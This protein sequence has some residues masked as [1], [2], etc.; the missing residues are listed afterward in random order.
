M[1][2]ANLEPGL[3][4]LFRLFL[5]VQLL[6]IYGNVHVHGGRGYLGNDPWNPLIFSA[7]SILLLLAYLSIP[8][9][10]KLLGA[11]YLPLALILS[12]VISL[13]AQDLLLATRTLFESGSSEEIAWQL[14]LFLFIPLVLTAWQYNFRAVLIFCLFSAAFDYILV[15]LGNPDFE[16]VQMTYARL[17]LIRTFAFLFVGYTIAR[18]VQQMRQQSLAL[19]QAND[20]LAHYATTLEQLSVSRERNRLA[21]ELHDTLAHTLSGLAVQLEGIRSII[22]VNPEKSIAM[23]ER[24]IE[25]TRSGLTET[26]KSIQSLRATPVDDLGIDL[27]IQELGRSAA[28]RA[29]FV[30]NFEKSEADWELPEDM[31]Q[32]LYRVAQEALENIVKHARAQNVSM[33]LLRQNRQVSLTISDDGAGFDPSTVEREGHYG[34]RGMCERAEIAGGKVTIDS[35][36]GNGTTLRLELETRD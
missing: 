27:A 21:R 24:S 10:Q 25:A 36:P 33:R 28:Q 6:L 18:I 20:K 3:L 23:L 31:E 17:T 5:I 35:A 29:G 22:Q 34:I 13:L 16:R 9:F 19:Q 12:V 11:F 30:F 1:R 14:F 32:C 26:R 8:W 2:S 4:K 15:R 7:I